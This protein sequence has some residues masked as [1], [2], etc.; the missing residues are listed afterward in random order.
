MRG[1]DKSWDYA[2]GTSLALW[3]RGG[4]VLLAK[5]P[6]VDST[7]TVLFDG[8]EPKADN[9]PILG[10]LQVATPIDDP[11]GIFGF[12]KQSGQRPGRVVVYGDSNCVDSA[13][14]TGPCWWLFEQLVA[15][16]ITGVIDVELEAGLDEL[17]AQLKATY[18]ELPV[19]SKAL[20]FER[21]SKVGRFGKEGANATCRKFWPFRNVP[22]QF[23]NY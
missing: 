12:R 2:S 15:Y 20:K 5:A 4:K 23:F 8:H 10:L 18:V 9:V 14:M 3:P 19:R 11:D 6:F 1:S 17:H 22:L 16:A 13:H 21:F 7:A